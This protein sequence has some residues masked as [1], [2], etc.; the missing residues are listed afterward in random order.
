MLSPLTL[1]VAALAVLA[2]LI[3]GTACIDELP[4]MAGGAQRP[5][6]LPQRLNNPF[7]YPP[8][9]YEQKVQGNV[10]LRIFIDTI[11]RVLPESTQVVQSSGYPAFDSAAVRG[12]QE[13]RFTPAR[14][15]G[16]PVPVS[17]LHPVYFRRRDVP[18]LPGDTALRDPR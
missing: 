2:V 5:D 14:A 8:R 3:T 10:M 1:A 13:L 17:V 6:E 9:L 11:G 16:A 4:R 12:S 7:H 18:A 15:R